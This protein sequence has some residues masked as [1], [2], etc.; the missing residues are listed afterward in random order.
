MSFQRCY[1]SA[2]LL[3]AGLAAH[4]CSF[5]ASKPTP[6][7]EAPL[8]PLISEPTLVRVHVGKVSL[9]QGAANAFSAPE[10]RIP[11]EGNRF[12]EVGFPIGAKQT[13][14]LDDY[15]LLDIPDDPQIP[16]AVGGDGP[17]APEFFYD[18]GD[19]NRKVELTKGTQETTSM[20]GKGADAEVL[21]VGWET[22]SPTILLLY[23]IPKTMKTVTF[24]H[25][26]RTFELDP[27][28]GLI[29]GKP[30]TAK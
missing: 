2:L 25:G 26:T 30:G 11:E 18:T 17:G 15:E 12:I 27:D 4:G 23:E 21:L 22:P 14:A 5:N 24:R 19:F 3:V 9:A 7:A 13:L 8:A 10:I 29:N 16:F 6:K 20:E 28:R 1:P